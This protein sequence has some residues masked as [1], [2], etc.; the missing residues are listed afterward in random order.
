MESDTE[1][2]TPGPADRGTHRGAEEKREG[3]KH[4]VLKSCA[5]CLKSLGCK[6][7]LPDFDTCELTHEEEFVLHVLSS[8]ACVPY[9]PDDPE[10]EKLLLELYDEVVSPADPLPPDAERDWKAIGFQSQN[11][12]TD[13]RG[14]GL[15]A[16][17]QL[18]FFAQNFHEEMLVLVQK[19]KQDVFP[20]AA[21]L[22]NATHMLGTFFDL[23]TDH[24]MMTGPSSVAA[25]ASPRCLKNF[26]KLCVSAAKSGVRSRG[27]TFKA[28]SLCSTASKPR[29]LLS[30]P[31]GES[32]AE[33]SSLSGQEERSKPAR[34]GIL[35]R[36]LGTAS[37]TEETDS[38]S[39]ASAR[40]MYVF[41][42]LFSCM[43]IRLDREIERRRGWSSTAEGAGEAKTSGAPSAAP[44][45]SEA[46]S[47][48]RRLVRLPSE[49]TALSGSASLA[50]APAASTGDAEAAHAEGEDEKQPLLTEAPDGEAGGR[51]R[52]RS[53]SDEETEKHAGEHPQKSAG[54]VADLMMHLKKSGQ[55]LPLATR[56]FLTS[57]RPD[58]SPVGQRGSTI[59]VFA[60]SLVSCRVAVEELLSSGEVHTVKDLLKLTVVD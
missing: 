52:T 7:C 20:L 41:N 15:L 49:S 2:A 8:A 59:F 1:Q 13:F 45:P 32:T 37:R 44:A 18:L 51:V 50:G 39:S 9:N 11:P 57:Q 55:E 30:N 40:V 3:E 29:S 58:N 31:R 5:L 23:Y 26:T 56:A 34:S 28:F 16:L 33:G 53:D 17:Q 22:I 47:S 36:R 46:S 27:S 14:G 24:H 38:L 60:D 35:S 48:A 43:V 6:W 12:R 4:G 19:S 42:Y 10:Q 54:S 25:R 21:S